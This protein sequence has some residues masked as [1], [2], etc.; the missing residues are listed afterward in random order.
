MIVEIGDK[1]FIATAFP[2]ETAF[3]ATV[4][5]LGAPP[6]ARSI[7]SLGELWRILGD[8]G[9][10]LI[11]CHPTYSAPWSWRHLTRT[12]FSRRM[13]R[14]EAPLLRAFAPQM[15]RWRGQAP[16]AVIDYEDL[17]V[18][19]RNNLFLLDRCKL[20][21]K[22]ELP[23]DHWRVFLKTAHPNLPTARFRLA[24]RNADR[25]AK[26]RPLSIGLPFYGAPSLDMPTQEKR[27]DVFYAGR[28][29]GSSTLRARG[30][31]ELRALQAKGLAVDIP[32]GTLPR[33]EFYRRCAGAWLVWSPEGY[34]W[35]CFRH[36]E[37][38]ACGSVPLINQPTIERR[39]RLLAG[40]H[41]LYYDVEPGG[42]TQA[43][44]AA[45][46]DKAALARIAR[47][48]R[49]YVLTH[50]TPTAIARDIVEMTRSGAA[51]GSTAAA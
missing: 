2:A 36:Y 37:A 41:A 5:G 30:L 46:A 11:V 34:G 9:V 40:E 38:L 29:D 33:D 32:D 45:L 24:A 31:G 8:P 43:I 20:F 12:V 27:F 39:A 21:F 51:S 44:T 50:H 15:L 3:Y 17:P 1:P 28:V 48:G 18:I 13:L 14:G 16:I 4:S 26:L 47:N 25:V 7:G 6:G 19:N 10:D 49:A 42:L 35:D 22:R 23:A